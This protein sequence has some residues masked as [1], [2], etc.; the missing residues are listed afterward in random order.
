MKMT[1]KVL[2]ILLSPLFLLCTPLVNMFSFHPVKTSADKPIDL[3]QGI[4]E[5]VIK[6]ADGQ[7]LVCLLAEPDSFDGMILYFHGNGGNIYH[8]TDRLLELSGYGKMV[9]GVSYRGYGKSSGK[10]S[11]AGL[12]Q[13]ARAALSFVQHELG[14]AMSEIIIYGRSVGTAVAVE[15]SQHIEPAR[16][17]LIAPLTSAKEMAKEMGFGFLSGIAGDAFNSLGKINHLKSPLLVIHGTDDDVIPF[18][19]GKKLFKQYR[20]EKKFVTIEKGNHD[21]I[22]QFEPEKFSSAIKAFIR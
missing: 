22:Q 3:P 17:I 21:Q 9:L 19:M 20:G 11:E 7:K 10:P 14:Y 5:V 4:K 2:S 15:L 16:V 12:Y 18:S 1:K 13:D 8:R 6:T